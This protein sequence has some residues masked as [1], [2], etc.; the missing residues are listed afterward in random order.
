MANKKIILAFIST[1]TLTSWAQAPVAAAP[2]TGLASPAPAPALIAA[3]AP[4]PA[5]TAIKAQSVPVEVFSL[6]QVPSDTAL[7][8]KRN[9]DN[10]HILKS[11]IAL[12]E[13]KAKLVALEKDLHRTKSDAM[14]PVKTLPKVVSVVGRTENLTAQIVFAGGTTRNIKKG[15]SLGSMTVHTIT[16]DEVILRDDGK[17]R[18]TLP[19][20]THLSIE[21]AIKES[22]V[23]AP[24]QTGGFLVPPKLPAF[25]GPLPP[26]KN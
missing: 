17:T 19:F 13:A 2:P 25:D 9:I 10:V 12:A 1:I 5:H 16:M 20:S 23:A 6:K 22:L 21:E 14:Q 11:R 15:D 3:P 7:E 8:S 26:I 18:I 24:E 4:T